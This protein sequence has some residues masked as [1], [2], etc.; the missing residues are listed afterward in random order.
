IPTGVKLID[1]FNSVYSE[2]AETAY[3]IMI[4]HHYFFILNNASDEDME[5]LEHIPYAIKRFYGFSIIPL[6]GLKNDEKIRESI[7][8]MRPYIEIFPES[9]TTSGI[10]EIAS[11]IVNISES[12]CY[13]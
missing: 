11:N 1:H 7:R 10:K 9:Q 6:G 13:D 5:L 12:L 4:N 2:L 3:Q 8:K